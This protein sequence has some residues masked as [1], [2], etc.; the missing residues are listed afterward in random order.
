MKSNLAQGKGRHTIEVNWDFS[1]C[2]EHMSYFLLMQQ[3]KRTN[4]PE[5]LLRSSIA[6]YRLRR[7]ITD[8]ANGTSSFL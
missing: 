5:S 1:K 2:Y 7:Y 6:M 4:Y 8:S 3:A